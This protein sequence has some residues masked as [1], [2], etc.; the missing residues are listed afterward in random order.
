MALK[1]VLLTKNQTFKLT[2][3]EQTNYNCQKGDQKCFSDPK[4]KN[5]PVSADKQY[6][7]V[8]GFPVFCSF[9]YCG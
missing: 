1:T 7:Y 9:V 8:Q 4:G 3:K 5:E 2:E 6:R